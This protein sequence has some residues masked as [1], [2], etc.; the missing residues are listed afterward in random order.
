MTDTTRPTRLTLLK[1]AFPGA[2]IRDEKNNWTL[3]YDLESFKA[4][5]SAIRKTLRDDPHCLFEIIG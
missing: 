2:A 5:Q 4:K 3:S 1:K